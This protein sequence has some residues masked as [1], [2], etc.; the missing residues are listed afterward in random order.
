MQQ[1]ITST[2]YFSFN[3]MHSFLGDL[4]QLHRNFNDHYH[5]EWLQLTLPSFAQLYLEFGI[6]YLILHLDIMC[7]TLN[8]LFGKLDLSSNI[9]A[10]YPLLMLLF[11]LVVL[12]FFQL[13]SETSVLSLIPLISSLSQMTVFKVIFC[14]VSSL[15]IY[16]TTHSSKLPHYS[17]IS[18]LCILRLIWYTDFIYFWN[19]LFPLHALCC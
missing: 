13:T 2:H 14:H 18:G 17:L 15:C 19:N 7:N 16:R 12:P 8:L 6:P 4:I 11:L 5:T 9:Q 10:L 3:Y 1:S